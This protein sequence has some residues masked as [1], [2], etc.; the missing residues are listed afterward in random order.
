[1]AKQ[2]TKAYTLNREKYKAIKKYDHQQLEDFCSMVYESGVKRG[3]EAGCTAAAD[4]ASGELSE[5]F[6][7][8]AIEEVLAA[9]AEV[10]GIGPKKL[11]EIRTKIGVENNEA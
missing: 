6:R 9:A 10:K 3:Y 1:M 4:A 11:E 2:K 5:K 8:I 7:K